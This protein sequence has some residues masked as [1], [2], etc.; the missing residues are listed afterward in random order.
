MKDRLFV[1]E[2][3]MKALF[4]RNKY[5]EELNITNTS[6]ENYKCQQC[7]GNNHDN[8]EG[9]DELRNRIKELEMQLAE[10]KGDEH[11]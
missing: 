5:L 7:S 10:A 6:G 8:T 3:V 1:T 2:K 9:I 11:F 4:K